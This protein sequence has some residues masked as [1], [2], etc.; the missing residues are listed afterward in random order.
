MIIL[1]ACGTKPPTWQEQYDLGVRYLEEGN[2]E[3]AIIAFTAA[4]EIDPKNSQGYLSLAQSYVGADD[5]DHAVEVLKQGWDNCPQ[6]SKLFEEQLKLLGYIIDQNGDLLSLEAIQEKTFEAYQEIL[7]LFY[8][9]I[10][11]HWS[12]YS[13]EDQTDLDEKISYLWY[14][15]DPVD[16]LS[17]AGYMLVDLNNDNVPELITGVMPEAESGMM[18]DLY[19]YSNGSVLHL[20]SSGERD[21]YYLCTD[22]IIA[23]EG[24]SG[25]VDSVFGFYKF[26]GNESLTLEELVR[27]YGM[28]P[29][30]GPWYYG[31]TDTHDVKQMEPI[32]ESTAMEIIDKYEYTPLELISFDHSTPSQ[33]SQSQ[34]DTAQTQTPDLLPID[35]IDMTIGELIELCGSDF[36]MAD[37]WYAGAAKPI[38]YSD[39]RVPLMFYFI[40]PELSNVAQEDDK[41]SLVECPCGE[42]ASFDEIAP[43]IS[44]QS[45]YT[46]L[47]EAGYSGDLYDV[48][49]GVDFY[50]EFGET[51]S[52]YMKYNSDTAIYFYWFN[53]DDPKTTCAQMAMI[54]KLNR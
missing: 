25:A 30:E 40:D 9:S 2:Y 53:N 43:G 38:Y 51:S 27:Y 47:I 46:Q 29:P 49:D 12:N 7:D 34:T 35:Y 11:T 45:T 22:H 54:W 37:Y 6:D 14:Y 26:E 44:T 5:V 42:D 4:I 52:F 31:K 18:Y 32:S 16:S 3:E 41:I 17:D 39:L 19:T 21:R 33:S 24:S 1:C 10:S 20:V 28:E 50:S 23:N 15:Y 48:Q 13:S 36:Q 8:Y